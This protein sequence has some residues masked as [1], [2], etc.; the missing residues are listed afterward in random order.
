[1]L[2]DEDFYYKTIEGEKSK[3]ALGHQGFLWIFS[4]FVF[5][6]FESSSY[7]VFILIT[8]LVYIPPHFDRKIVIVVF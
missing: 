3:D 1:M 4:T 8:E 2:S 7:N 5:T 6:S